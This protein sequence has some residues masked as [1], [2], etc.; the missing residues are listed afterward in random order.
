MLPGK[1]G[2]SLTTDQYETLKAL[3]VAGHIDREIEGMSG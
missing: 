3:I 2:I 1:K